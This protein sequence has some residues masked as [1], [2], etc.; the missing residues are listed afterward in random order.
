MNC[1]LSMRDISCSKMM[2]S[3]IVATA[4]DIEDNDSECDGDGAGNHLDIASGTWRI[5]VNGNGI[6]TTE[7]HT[8]LQQPRKRSTLS[9]DKHDG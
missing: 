9:C 2:V 1:L 8:F 3:M 4:P 6:S 5:N 7:N